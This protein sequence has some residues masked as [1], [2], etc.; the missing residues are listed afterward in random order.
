MD[1]SDILKMKT[2]SHWPFFSEFGQKQ[3][4]WLFFVQK[5]IFDPG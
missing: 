4:S 2:V 3:G 5:E 1:G